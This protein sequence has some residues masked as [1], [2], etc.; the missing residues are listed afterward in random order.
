MKLLLARLPTRL[1]SKHPQMIE[2]MVALNNAGRGEA[3]AMMIKMM[4]DLHQHGRDSRYLRAMKGTPIKELKP[5]SRGGLKGGSRVYLFITEHEEAGIVTCEVK[6][7]DA[8]D[9][10]KLKRVLRVVS[11]HKDGMPVLRGRRG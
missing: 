1:G 5:R 7:G 9:P 4:G 11:A 2:E 6:G 3:V 10:H 8:P